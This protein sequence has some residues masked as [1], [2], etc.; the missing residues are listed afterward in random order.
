M[1]IPHIEE[2]TV[3]SLN[4]L[5][6]DIAQRLSDEPGKTV[7][8]CEHPHAMASLTSKSWQQQLRVV[9][10]E[11][12][13]TLDPQKKLQ[14]TRIKEEMRSRRFSA[15]GKPERIETTK[16][17]VLFCTVEQLPTYALACHAMYIT[18]PID[19]EK[20][21]HITAWMGPEDIV[22]RYHI[23]P[24]AKRKAAPGWAYRTRHRDS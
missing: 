2:R 16:I 7:V 5:A 24:P 8:V 9:L 22:I 20:L 3:T 15:A 19:K 17:D 1:Y 18:H 13:G 4:A 11:L 21:Y 12:A 23:V 10:R 14:L 6:Q